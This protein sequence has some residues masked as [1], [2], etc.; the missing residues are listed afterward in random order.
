M[1]GIIP[2]S[3]RRL[4]EMKDVLFDRK[5]AAKADGELPLYYMHRAIGRRGWLRY[6]VT[7]LPP[8]MLGSEYNKTLG[9]YHSIAKRGLAYPE[10]YEVL[11]GAATYILQK[12]EKGKI[13]D[14]I[15]CD[16][17]AGDKILMPPNYGHVTVNRG[18]GTLIMSNIVCDHCMSDYSDYQKMKGAAYYIIKGKGVIPNPAFKSLPKPCHLKPGQGILHTSLPEKLTLYQLLE[19][20][21]R[22][23]QFLEDPR[24]L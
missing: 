18:K 5:F 7:V 1:E 3:V 15:I 16:A 8:L 11:H 20:N 2:P 19:N 21:S 6:D 13:A 12:K 14:V 4:R 10:I 17:K 24:L 23:L 9:H 22:L